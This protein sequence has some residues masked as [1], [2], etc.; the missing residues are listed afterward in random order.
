MK[1]F[2]YKLIVFIG[3]VW[4]AVLLTSFILFLGFSR[5]AADSFIE[6]GSGYGIIPYGGNYYLCDNYKKGE[7]FI[8]DTCD[9][10]SEDI[11]KDFTFDDRYIL[12]YSLPEVDSTAKTSLPYFTIIDKTSREVYGPLS[13]ENYLVKRSE[14]D[15]PDDLRLELEF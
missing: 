3:L 4:W 14:L 12:L 5:A 11:V 15:V 1:Y 13:L 6:L 8:Y 7:I 10:C 9:Q 2:K